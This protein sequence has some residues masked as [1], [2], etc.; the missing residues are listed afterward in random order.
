MRVRQEV[1]CWKLIRS[2]SPVCRRNAPILLQQSELSA[3]SG[4]FSFSPSVGETITSVLFHGERS[5]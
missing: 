3:V 5:M 2:Q 1:L 4:H